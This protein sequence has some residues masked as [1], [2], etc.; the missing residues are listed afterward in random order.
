MDSIFNHL[1]IDLISL[2]ISYLKF[3]EW[4]I[5]DNAFSTHSEERKRWLQALRLS[6][7]DVE[8]ETKNKSLDN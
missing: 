3:R 2:L 8:I 4:G 7:I 6:T 5:L 1:P